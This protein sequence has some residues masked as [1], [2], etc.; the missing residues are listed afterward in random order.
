[1]LV[2]T[3]GEFSKWAAYKTPLAISCAA[4]AAN[5]CQ[6]S[7]VKSADS[8]AIA[9][10]PNRPIAHRQSCLILNQQVISPRL[11]IN[12][13]IIKTLINQVLSLCVDSLKTLPQLP[14]FQPL[15]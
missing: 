12:H 10:P 11:L 15:P 4:I 1:M 6:L 8:F 2:T 14:T 9:F 13:K 7:S 3:G 5:V